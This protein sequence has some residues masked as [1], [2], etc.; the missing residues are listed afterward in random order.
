MANAKVTAPVLNDA[1][2]IS[3]FNVS[4]NDNIN[5]RM[6]WDGTCKCA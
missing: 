2:F 6:G 4:L 1:V 5:E 3:D